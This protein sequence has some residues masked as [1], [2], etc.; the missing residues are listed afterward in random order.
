M[1]RFEILFTRP[2]LTRKENW[3]FQMDMK[4]KM[5]SKLSFFVAALASSI[6]DLDWL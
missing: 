6:T 3:S 4:A 1:K 5:T 2:H